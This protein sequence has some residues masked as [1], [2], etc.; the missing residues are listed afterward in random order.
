VELKYFKYFL[1]HNLSAVISP[2]YPC[3]KK[4]FLSRQSD[5]LSVCPAED[6]FSAAIVEPLTNESVRHNSL[7]EFF[8]LPDKLKHVE[9]TSVSSSSETELLGVSEGSK[10]NWD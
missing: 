10:K 2:V 6:R 7:S 5:C 1:E 3:Q 8:L 4:N 9:L